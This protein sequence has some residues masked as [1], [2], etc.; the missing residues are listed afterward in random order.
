MREG[1]NL[2]QPLLPTAVPPVLVVRPG[3]ATAPV[4]AR[5]SVTLDGRYGLHP[6]L[7]LRR[8]LHAEHLVA[9]AADHHLQEHRLD[10]G[11]GGAAPEAAVVAQRAPFT[12]VELGQRHQQRRLGRRQLAVDQVALRALDDLPVA[13]LELAVLDTPLDR[14]RAAGALHAGVVDGQVAQHDLLLGHRIGGLA[15]RLADVV[16]RLQ[17]VLCEPRQP[18]AAQ[19]GPA[20]LHPGRGR[21]LVARVLPLGTGTHAHRFLH[22]FISGTNKGPPLSCRVNDSRPS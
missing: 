5:A 20:A 12:G 10:V 17:V 22:F 1:V 14:G 8:R 9:V 18:L 3:A 4:P 15:P 21:G 16:R 13:V 7:A 11:V 19:L 2:W 6:A